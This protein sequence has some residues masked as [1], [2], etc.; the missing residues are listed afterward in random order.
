MKTLNGSKNMSITGIAI[1]FTIFTML[2]SCTKSA[3]SDM[4]GTGGDTGGPKGPGTNEVFIQGMA[5]NPATITVAAN[6]TITWTNKD[7][8]GHTVTS[9]DSLFDSGII[10]TNET[11]SFTFT[12]AGTYPYHC[13][14][15]PSMK[16][17]VKVN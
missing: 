2:N 3:M 12:T 9:D 8:V 5:F 14:P 7:A 13:T 11:F 6:T 16:A 17:T 10:G 15:H 4:T 1:L